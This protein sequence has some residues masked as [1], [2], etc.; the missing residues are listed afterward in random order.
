MFDAVL[1]R[2]PWDYSFQYRHSDLQGQ[3]LHNSSKP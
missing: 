3:N 1:S 2:R